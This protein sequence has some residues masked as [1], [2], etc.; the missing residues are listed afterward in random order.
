MAGEGV[1]DTIR[2]LPTARHRATASVLSGVVRWA[3][4][5][6]AS[7]ALGIGTMALLLGIHPGF[8]PF[9][10]ATNAGIP[11][12]HEFARQISSG[13]F[14]LITTRSFQGGN[15]LVN[16]ANG[17]YDPL[18]LAAA[19]FTLVTSNTTLVMA[20]FAALSI[21][22]VGLGGYALGRSLGLSYPLAAFVGFTI[23]TAPQLVF[24]YVGDWG[25]GA[26][27]QAS[28]VWLAVALVRA[29]K[30]PGAANLVFVAVMTFVL[31]LSGWPTAWIAFPAVVAATAVVALLDPRIGG[32]S[33]RSRLALLWR[34][35]AALLAGVLVAIPQFS[36]FLAAGPLLSRFDEWSDASNYA[37]PSPS[38]IAGLG[39]PTAS[40]WWQWFFSGYVYW[41]VPLGFVSI[42]GFVAVF[43]VRWNWALARRTWVFW[44]LALSVVAALCCELPYR[45]GSSQMPFRF[46]PIFGMFA[47]VAIALALQHGQFVWSRRRFVIASLAVLV[48]QAYFA[49][50]IPSLSGGG[51]RQMII[52]F[53]LAAAVVLVFWAMARPTLRRVGLPL[54]AVGG[55]VFV[56]L[57]ATPISNYTA[58]PGSNNAPWP[59]LPTGGEALAA[60]LPASDTGFVLDVGENGVYEN[61]V[62]PGYF[63]ARYLLANVPILNGYDPVGRTAFD[64]RMDTV[65]VQGLVGDRSIEF[66]SE[67]SISGTGCKFDDYRV[68]SVITLADPVAGDD[69]DLE[70]CGFTLTAR[71]DNTA[72]WQHPLAA[73][74]GTLSTTTRGVTAAD[75]DLTSEI[76]E[77]A[78]VSNP[79]QAPGDVAFARMWWPGYTATLDGKP[80]TVTTTD[81]MLVT[82][83]VPPGAHGTLELRYWPSTWH[84]ALPVAGLGIV[85][86]AG[87]ASAALVL[88]RRRRRSA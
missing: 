34:I 18:L 80:L 29:A 59:P 72:L 43:F 77:T 78:Q 56:M 42:A 76:D 45:V 39:L 27:G 28:L 60:P 13:Q 54:L 16:F 21:A 10:D 64:D 20:G 30:R 86:A 52:G 35:G 23:G 53:S 7:I 85:G 46:L 68:S 79:G 41:D 22:A 15:S 44:S 40:D 61:D 51:G 69:K 82:V 9:D 4:P 67:R 1:N 36:E 73:E 50:R 8:L 24:L 84:W 71:R 5:I 49:F 70:R 14:P 75:D 31:F 17:P 83:V 48:G 2:D 66:L 33:W 57:T 74:S 87:V 38:L 58:T 6:L 25:T 3:A 55:A 62:W 81:S 11:M 12:W 47:S 37:V 65:S 32:T 88:D 19:L 63:S 26:A